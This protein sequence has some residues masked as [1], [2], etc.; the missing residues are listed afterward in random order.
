MVP[1][2]SLLSLSGQPIALIKGVSDAMMTHCPKYGCRYYN[3]G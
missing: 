1:C 3:H 2:A